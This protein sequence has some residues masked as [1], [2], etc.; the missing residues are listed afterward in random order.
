M[1]APSWPRR[2]VAWPR[3]SGAGRLPAGRAIAPDSADVRTYLALHYARTASGKERFYVE[4]G[5][6]GQPDKVP[7]LEALAVLH[8]TAGGTSE[9]STLRQRVYTLR[10]HHRG[11]DASGRAGDGPRINGACNRVVRGSCSLN[12]QT[13]TELGVLYL[14]SD[15]HR[16]ET[17]GPRRLAIDPMYAMAFSTRR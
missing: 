15:A 4:R 16:P 9:L 11:A 17:R 10:S 8:Q 12:L 13:D 7:A 14:A 1:R 5:R 3:T 6:G 2:I